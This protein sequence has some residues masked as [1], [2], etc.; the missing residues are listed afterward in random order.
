M[1]APAIRRFIA[2]LA[3]WWRA[4]AEEWAI[5]SA[6]LEEEHRQEQARASIRAR[7]PGALRRVT[8]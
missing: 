4:E 1:T 5:W 3:A 8:R 2:A 6:A 7:S